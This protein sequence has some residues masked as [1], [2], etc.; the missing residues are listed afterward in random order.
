MNTLPIA[1]FVQRTIED[2]RQH[3]LDVLEN[4]G[5]QNMEQY[6]NLMGELTAL[7]LVQQE[8]SGLLEKQEHI[9]DEF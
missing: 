1:I 2:R 4:N 7:K 8:L 5:I 9:D 3:I 6:A